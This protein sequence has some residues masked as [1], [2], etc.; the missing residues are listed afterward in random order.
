MY[1]S[2]DDAKTDVILAAAVAVLGV[3]LRAYLGQMPGY[4]VAGLMGTLLELV[5]VVAL[6]ALVPW[7]LVRY[8]ND[9]VGAFGVRPSRGPVGAVGRARTAGARSLTAGLVIALP[10]ALAGVAVQLMQ[11]HTAGA[12]LGRLAGSGI[13]GPW[14]VTDTALSGVR[15]A[16]L[17][18]GAL[19]LVGF[20]SV[21]SRDGFTRSPDTDLTQLVRGIGMGAVGVALVS[22]LLLSL[23]RASLTVVLINVAAA[24]GVVILADRFVPAGVS[25]PR[26]AIIAPVIVV[27]AGRVFASGGLIFGDLLGWLYT[28]ALAT[29]LTLAI[30][31]F[32]QTR[33]GTLVAVP[34]IV[35]AHW[36]PTCLSPTVLAGGVC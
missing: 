26:A 2:P 5:W 24:A 15:V 22:G 9:G 4:P 33:R 21:R 30:A 3:S 28:G 14:S 35:A 13:G 34:A 32:A 19:A 18:V 23:G 16:L 12:L 6:T 27:V 11:S 31:A 36:W 29:G 20:L 25:V 1:L 10:V 8:R 17:S 7:L